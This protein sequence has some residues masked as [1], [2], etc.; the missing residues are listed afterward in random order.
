MQRVPSSRSHR[1]ADPQLVPPFNSWKILYHAHQKLPP[2]LQMSSTLGANFH[3]K[4]PLK[5]RRLY[6]LLQPVLLQVKYFNGPSPQ[7]LHHY[8]L[9]HPDHPPRF[10]SSMSLITHGTQSKTWETLKERQVK[11][12]LPSKIPTSQLSRVSCHEPI[13]SCQVKVKPKVAAPLVDSP[14]LQREQ[15]TSTTYPVF[16]FGR[17]SFNQVSRLCQVPDSSPVKG[18]Q[19]WQHP[20]PVV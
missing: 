5:V 17:R 3:L 11:P 14:S 10:H 8:P 18:G 9:P 7:V 15:G 6:V 16:L 20:P 1:G 19:T 4:W 2:Q 12:S 13:S